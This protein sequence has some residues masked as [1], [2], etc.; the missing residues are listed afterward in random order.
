MTRFKHWKHILCVHT[1]V[2]DEYDGCNKG[3]TLH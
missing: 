1:Y 3:Y 2:Y